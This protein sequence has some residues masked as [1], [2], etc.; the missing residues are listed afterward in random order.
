MKYV[1]RSSDF[2]VGDF[3]TAMYDDKVIEL[4]RRCIL[5]RMEVSIH[6]L[7]LSKELTE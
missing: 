1:R 7:L 6:F 2:D 4:V 5:Y 3:M